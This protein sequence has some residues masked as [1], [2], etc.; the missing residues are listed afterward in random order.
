[1]ESKFFSVDQIPEDSGFSRESV[2]H[3][4]GTGEL[5]LYIKHGDS[6]GLLIGSKKTDFVKQYSDGTEGRIARE[7]YRRNLAQSP[8]PASVVLD[9]GIYELS[10]PDAAN[11]AAHLR[12]AN[13]A[14]CAIKQLRKPGG[15]TWYYV[16]FIPND[17]A[18]VL[19][20]I[21]RYAPSLA[22]ADVLLPWPEKPLY[23]RANNLT[24]A[25]HDFLNHC[26]QHQM[27]PTPG[28]LLEFFKRRLTKKILK[29]EKGQ[30]YYYDS[31]GKIVSRTQNQAE[32]R[33]RDTKK[34]YP[35]FR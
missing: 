16:G 18:G 30:V 35:E 1:M 2:L 10:A 32:R 31:K 13:T 28:N 17:A 20:E 34:K 15:Q 7:A 22:E 33:L 14:G 6:S 19:S 23:V 11:I 21:T 5:P 12:N 26:L 25:I 24:R 9:C 4:C 27:E 8:I 29:A 3:Q